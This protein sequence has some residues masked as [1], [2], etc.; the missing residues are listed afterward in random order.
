MKTISWKV[1]W[2]FMLLF[3]WINTAFSQGYVFKVIASSAA[4]ETPNKSENGNLK[5]GTKLQAG[6]KITVD[7]KGYLA[8][9]HAQGGTIQISKK[10][11][12]SIGE[13][14]INLAKNQKTLGK[15]YVDFVIGSVVKNGEVDIH[16]NPHKYQNVTGSV[17][18]ALVKDLVVMLPKETKI[19][20][21][22][23]TIHWHAL[24]GTK[25]YIIEIKNA[26]GELVKKYE[27]ADTTLRFNTKDF[28]FNDEVVDLTVFSKE[29]PKGVKLGEYGLIPLA[30]D[31]KK[32]F[33][34][35]YESFKNEN[36]S[37]EN[38]A[39][40]KLLE[41]SFFEEHKLML[42]ALTAYESA[43]KLSNNEEVY[44]I[45]LK[46]FTIRYNIG[47]VEHLKKAVD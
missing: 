2:I 8:L 28:N 25:T 10:G 44:D 38:N 14:E 19:I 20:F 47:R 15:K 36:K 43:V 30:N 11:T 46:Q 13:L 24:K 40:Y 27:T 9:A 26:M 17:E 23:N 42:D 21:E 29:R 16:K 34:T 41:A 35:A 6:S 31:Q 37:I 18:R 5:I 45:A 22:E 39:H 4:K 3:M 33:T 32:S 7:N 12:W 1:I